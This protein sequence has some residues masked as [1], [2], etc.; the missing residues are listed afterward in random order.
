MET[1][2]YY[3]GERYDTTGTITADVACGRCGANLRGQHLGGRCPQCGTPTGR[4][5]YG[6]LL[7]YADPAWL[8]RV[9]A[10]LLTVLWGMIAGV[11]ALGVSIV[12]VMILVMPGAMAAGRTA[13]TRPGA[14]TA[15]TTTFQA[16]P[17]GTEWLVIVGAA[18][19][20]AFAIVV[21]HGTWG[22]TSG[23]P[24]DP[25]AGGSAR[26]IARGALLGTFAVTA[27]QWGLQFTG[28]DQFPLPVVLAVGG[29]GQLFQ[30]LAFVSQAH[31]LRRLATRVPDAGVAGRA[32]LIAWGV[33]IGLG[34]TMV[35]Q[36]VFLVA[37]G[38]FR[39]GAAPFTPGQMTNIGATL[40]TIGCANLLI[41]LALLAFFVV[42]LVTLGQLAG[43]VGR[44][45]EYAAAVW[46]QPFGGPAAR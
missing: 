12:V 7:Q 42:Y 5:V 34:L 3:S 4:S 21:A 27:G 6:D 46:A 15:T 30:L 20:L 24:A 29:I 37:V 33:G 40:A 39:P 1:L 19:A 16:M 44:A 8:G 45:R 2:G 41:G 9:R 28:I 31:V 35:L 38:Q 22:F 18:V 10:G 26:G 25:T 36:G 14:A 17:P 32:K 13:A 23:D 43:R 11:V